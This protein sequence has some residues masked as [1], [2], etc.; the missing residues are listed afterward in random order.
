ME[1]RIPILKPNIGPGG[2]KVDFIEEDDDS[3]KRKKD[4]TEAQKTQ[5]PS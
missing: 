5:Q 3:P 4:N 2:V 1:H